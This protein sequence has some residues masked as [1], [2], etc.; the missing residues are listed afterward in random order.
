[1]ETKRTDKDLLIKGVKI[2]ILTALLMFLGPTLVYMALGNKASNLYEL[3]LI[4]G[5]LICIGAIYAGFF[6]IKTIMKSMF[7]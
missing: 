5:I 3:T 1:M 2:M 7:D 6:G 4:V